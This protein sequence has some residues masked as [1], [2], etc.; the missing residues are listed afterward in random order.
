M[1]KSKWRKKAL[2]PVAI[3]AAV[4]MTTTASSTVLALAADAVTTGGVSKYYSDYDSLDDAKTAAERLT[5]ELASEGDVLLKNKN[6]AL[7]M[8]GDSKVSVFGV[9]SDNLVG[10]SDSAGAFGSSATSS[11]EKVADALEEAGFIVNPT[12]KNFYA[13]DTS[14]HGN[15]VTEDGFSGKAKQSMEV[16]NDAAVV[17]F[18]RE[19]GEGSDASTTKA[20]HGNAEEAKADDGT[21]KE[22]YTKDGK[23]YK[24]SLM[25]TDS[26]QAL[27]KYVEGKFDKVVVVLNTSNA[28][29][30]DQLKEDDGIDAIVHIGR[31]GVGGLAALAGILNGTY[32]PSGRL[33]DE[34][35]ADFSADPTWQ[36]F[37]D[38]SQTGSSTMYL[39]EAG[40]SAYEPTGGGMV[41]SGMY[42]VDYEESIYLGYKY[43]ET[44]YQDIYYGRQA[45]PAGY[46]T[47]KEEA[48]QKW[49][50]DN[51]TY[52]FGYGL[53]Y[54]TFSMNV[55][56]MYYNLDG[57]DVEVN[58]GDDLKTDLFDSSKDTNGGHAKVEKLFVDVDVK[59]TGKVAGKQV[60]Q[61]YVTAPY[62][63]GG[64]EKSAVTL[65]GYGK[66]DE[67]APG[68]TQTVT[69]SFNVQDMASW[70]YTDANKD[71]SKGD[72]ELDAGEY[73]VRVMENS[74][75]DC[76]TD[77]TNTADAYDQVKFDLVGTT[78]DKAAN[79]KTDDFSGNAVG[80]L[81]STENGVWGED[82][83]SKTELNYNSI[84]TSTLAADGKAA[85]TQM[86]RS[87]FA[88]TFPDSPTK[89]DVTFND[90]AIA[91]WLSWDE[92][93]VDTLGEDGKAVYKDKETDP[94]YVSEDKIP[95][96]WAQAATAGAA[97]SAK[98]KYS[99]MSG[100]EWGDKKWDEF[101]NQLT[102]EELCS[103]VENGGYGTT[104]IESVGKLQTV[105]ADG[106]NNLSSSHCWCSEDI[107]S[108][109]WNTEL[110]AEQGRLVGNIALLLGTQGWYGPGMDTHRSPFSG[111]NNEYYSQDGLQGGYIAA[112]VVKGAQ[113][114]GV[115][116]YVKHCFLNDQETNRDGKVLFVWANEQ[117]IRE[118]YAKV[119]QMALQEGGSKAAMTGYARIGG[120]PNTSNYN[121]MTGLF[122]NEWGCKA[123]FVTD[124]Y[125]GWQDATELDI[126]VR[127]GY[128]LQLYTSPFVEELSG[129]WD[130]TKGMVVL[131]DGSESPT[132]WYH[133]RMSAKA[134]LYGGANTTSQFN[135]YSL[136]SIAGKQFEADTGVDFEGSVGI[137]AQLTAG[138]TVEYSIEG[139]LPQGIEFNE[140]TGELSGTPTQAGAFEFTVNYLIDGYVEKS[141]KCSI[142]VESSLYMDKDGDSEKDMKVGQEFMAQIKSDKF[143]TG[144]DYETVEYTVASGNLP[145][146]IT[147][148]KDG[149]FQGTPTT[150]GTY[151]VT[152]RMTATPA[153]G[154]SGGGF[155]DKGMGN[156][157]TLEEMGKVF[158]FESIVCPHLLHNGR[159]VSSTW[160]RELVAKG[161]IDT[162]SELLGRYYEIEG[163]VTH[164]RQEGRKMGFPTC[165]MELDPVLMEPRHGVYAAYADIEGKSFKCA[166]N[167]GIRPTF[168]LEK[169]VAE[170]YIL[171]YE[172]G[173]LY[174]KDVRLRLKGFI[175]DEADFGG[176]V[177]LSRRIEK[178]VGLIK[179]LL[180]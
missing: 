151:T 165:N 115:I 9:T 15:E 45:I 37:G 4:A 110:A 83:A 148:G 69:V 81:F 93:N 146:G 109:T 46:G 102:Y 111:R 79:M 19:G 14:K 80:N 88:K 161:G 35:M 167:I 127:T 135:G 11:D 100:V 128:Q 71:G 24:H 153:G 74:H 1:I 38:N 41:K 120:I 157:G 66:T 20:A 34:W 87:D 85:M 116:T 126:M 86:S 75:F 141:A 63:S 40:E 163:R 90:D 123:Y 60:V 56:R 73:I 98:I 84:R 6:N 149:I 158:G 147:L 91:N 133:V 138:S 18:S 125:I 29:E 140:N 107:I 131:A 144:A 180:K 57:K 92:Y 30:I 99:D 53:S 164:G 178:D 59:N 32:N 42:G 170:F 12:L 129:T 43:Y 58:D 16:Y 68:E 171:D 112:A 166:L 105:D 134:V 159:V 23:Q 160:I 142:T 55:D 96:S 122:Q 28:M 114:K 25:L 49:W 47:N 72:Y 174:G 64:I 61:I 50:A 76:A 26:E 78:G 124:G 65:V 108:S 2:V 22:L 82:E 95:D 51:V 62:T 168:G 175:R 177:E 77:L 89:A 179:E 137:A 145:D 27:L 173:E 8:A 21:H 33:V 119:F 103:I 156:C 139:M 97:G 132:Q 17:V 5:E 54:T 130:A 101:L 113:S 118:N 10:A 162:A 154:S 117:T 36:N 104:A 152:I 143:V 39:N 44:Y 155:G 172:G 48:A 67:L 150:A 7:P 70:D 121:L 106:P 169:T 31:P 136:L 13:Q 176:S 3:L 94:W 52:P